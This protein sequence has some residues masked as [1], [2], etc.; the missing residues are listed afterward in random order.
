MSKKNVQRATS[1][2]RVDEELAGYVRDSPTPRPII[3][4]KQDEPK[5]D[6]LDRLPT[7]EQRV[8]T[9]M[10]ETWSEASVTAWR[11]VVV[12]AF[13]EIRAK[14]LMARVAFPIHDGG[15]E[16]IVDDAF[17]LIAILGALFTDGEDSDE[18]LK[19]WQITAQANAMFRNNTHVMNAAIAASRDIANGL[20]VRHEA[21]FFSG[22]QIRKMID[23][24]I[25]EPKQ[26]PYTDP[27]T[28]WNYLETAMYVTYGSDMMNM[29][30]FG[31]LPE[32]NFLTRVYYDLKLRR[33]IVG[34]IYSEV[35]RRLPVMGLN[36]RKNYVDEQGFTHREA[37]LVP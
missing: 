14:G 5:A 30:C 3:V 23:R 20:L 24:G 36:Y 9:T 1:A 19:V 16:R 18:E 26:S 6:G 13:Q 31:E 7:L 2:L 12:E 15:W 34:A 35:M 10:Q 37:V 22:K 21:D 33:T 17:N 8:L 29:L 11:P 27:L 32:W 4:V 28:Q 25:W